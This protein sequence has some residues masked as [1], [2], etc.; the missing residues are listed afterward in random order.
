MIIVE[1]ELADLLNKKPDWLM[2]WREVCEMGFLQESFCGLPVKIAG[3][4]YSPTEFC[5]WLRMSILWALDVKVNAISI[6]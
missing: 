5:I 4:E 6:E 3:Q 1:K 2:S